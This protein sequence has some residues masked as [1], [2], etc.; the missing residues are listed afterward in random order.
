MMSES[1]LLA[2]GKLGTTVTVALDNFAEFDSDIT[3]FPGQLE[4]QVHNSSCKV[5]GAVLTLVA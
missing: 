1:G 5:A 4:N 2:V 3:V